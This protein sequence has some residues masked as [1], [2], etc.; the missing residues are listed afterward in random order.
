MSQDGGPAGSSAYGWVDLGDCVRP[1]RAPPRLPA[2]TEWVY[3]VQRR[4]LDLD[5]NGRCVV[6]DVWLERLQSIPDSISRNYIQRLY[7]FDGKRWAEFIAP[8]LAYYPYALQGPDH[9]TVFVRAAIDADV[10]DDHVLAFAPFAVFQ[11][12]SGQR[13]LFGGDGSALTPY[14]GDPRPIYQALAQRLSERLAAGQ[15]AS[16]ELSVVDKAIRPHVQKERIAML[17]KAAE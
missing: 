17:L 1:K 4:F 3:N 12:A 14:A 15:L 16:G 13:G 5:R 10:G 6:M 9:G 8:D 2:E 7:R 11:A